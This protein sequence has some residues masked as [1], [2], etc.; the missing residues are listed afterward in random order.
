[1]ADIVLVV[2]G[3]CAFRTFPSAQSNAA[4]VTATATVL[5]EKKKTKILFTN[6]GR[7]SPAVL[8]VVR[9]LMFESRPNKPLKGRNHGT[10]KK[11]NQRRQG[12]VSLRVSRQNK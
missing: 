9:L 11:R 5:K 10:R 6:R 1:M 3:V 12:N 7:S 4:H 2:V 8:A